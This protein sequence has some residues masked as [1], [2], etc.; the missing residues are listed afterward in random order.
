MPRIVQSVIP[1]ERIRP[2]HEGG[3]SPLAAEYPKLPR[4]AD[5]PAMRENECLTMLSS[6]NW[7]A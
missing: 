1:H 3:D 6:I 2:E 4:A 7:G 5:G